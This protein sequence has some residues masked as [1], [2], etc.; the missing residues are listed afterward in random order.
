[1]GLAFASFGSR[2]AQ[3]A[4]CSATAINDFDVFISLDIW[5]PAWKKISLRIAP[6]DDS[7]EKGLRLPS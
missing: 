7:K 6:L 1:M 3:A 5:G 2:P 4:I